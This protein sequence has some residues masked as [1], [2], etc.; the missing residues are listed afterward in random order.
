MKK[1]EAG[2]MAAR[3]WELYN[4]L[5]SNRGLLKPHLEFHLSTALQMFKSRLLAAHFKKEMFTHI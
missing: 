4:R 3:E 2:S 5:E 1:C